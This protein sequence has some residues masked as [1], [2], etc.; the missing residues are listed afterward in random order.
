ML[1]MQL[2]GPRNGPLENPR[3]S[4]VVT[5]CLLPILGLVRT[6]LSPS[7]EICPKHGTTCMYSKMKEIKFVYLN[8]KGCKLR[9][10]LGA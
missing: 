1:G 5:E 6:E 8:V 4:H 10:I 9:C 2:E 7:D 3:T